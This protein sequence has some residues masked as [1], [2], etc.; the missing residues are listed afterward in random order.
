MRLIILILLLP[1]VVFSQK[2]DT[3]VAGKLNPFFEISGTPPD[4][5]VR[6]IFRQPGLSSNGY[7]L[8]GK[9]LFLTIYVGEYCYEFPVASFTAPANI[10]DGDVFTAIIKDFTGD[11]VSIPTGQAAMYEKTMNTGLLPYIPELPLELEACMMSNN[12]VAI[13]GISGGA[14]TDDQTAAEVPVTP[15]GNLNSTDV[16]AALEEHQSDIDALASGGSDGVATAG[17]YDGVN[18]EIDIT[19]NAPGVGF[20]IDVSAL[21]DN[22]D[23]QDLSLSGNTLSLTGDPTTVDLSPY[24]DDTN[25][26]Q[27][28]VEDIAGGLF[29]GNTETLITATYQTLD[30]TVDLVVENNLALYDNSSSGFLTSEIDGSVTNEGSLSVS[31]GGGNSAHINSNTTGSS[32]VVIEGGSNVTI[33]ENTNN[34]TIIITAQDNQTATE[35]SYDNSTSLLATSTVQGAIDLLENEIDAVSSGASDGV[36]TAGVL[37][38]ANQEIDLTVASPGSNFSIPLTLLPTLSGFSGWDQDVSDD[39]DGNYTSLDFTGTTGLS[40]G[41]DNEGTDDQTAAEVNYDN[42]TSLL[43][44]STVQGAI[45]ILENEIDAISSATSD[46]VAT[47]GTLDTGNEEIDITVN[48]A[49][50]FSIDISNIANIAAF[51]QFLTTTLVQSLILNGNS[52]RNN[53]GTP[54]ISMTDGGALVLPEATGTYSP[55]SN[56]ELFYDSNQLQYRANGTTRVVN[57]WDDLLNIPS[58]L[59]DGTVTAA[60]SSYSTISSGLSS[61]TVQDAIDD[62]A[63]TPNETTLGAAATTHSVDLGNKQNHIELVSLTSTDTNDQIDLT[64]TNPKNGGV[65]TFHFIGA[66]GEEIGWPSNFYYANETQMPQAASPMSLTASD[67]FTCYYSSTNSRFYCK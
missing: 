52:I 46:G 25:L 37:D 6:G 34:E 56:G 8:T 18:E 1:V 24:L 39:F 5:T 60:E 13:D 43:E 16:Q 29:S 51:N 17:V 47:A 38:V 28:E 65:Y 53:I 44:T 62:I 12:M 10:Q 55:S 40:D 2:L 23:A 14:G 21:L 3:L 31:T 36:A 20:S 27:A 45:D 48:G 54:G 7:L 32:H 59:S 49:A 63:V 64:V 50:D 22:T 9:D 57:D 15:T 41:I 30:N 11:I 26:S 66:D 19:V 58:H 4:F 61:T 33:T 42:S 67:F 35:V